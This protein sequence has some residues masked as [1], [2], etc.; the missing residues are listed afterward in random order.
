MLEH[1]QDAVGVEY[2]P[3]RHP[4]ARLLSQLT[5]EANA[6]KFIL[7]GALQYAW[8]FLSFLGHS[9]GA[10][11][12]VR[13]FSDELGLLHVRIVSI[14]GGLDALRFQAGQALGLT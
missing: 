7:R 8:R 9:E 5:R 13:A 4:H 3:T 14:Q 11:W 10:T 12:R 6:T 2:M 1:H